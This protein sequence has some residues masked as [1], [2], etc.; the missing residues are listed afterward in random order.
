MISDGA[1][2]NAYLVNYAALFPDGKF[3]H[4]DFVIIEHST[5]S[6]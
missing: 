3:H 2:L 5:E 6:R 4:L 1:E